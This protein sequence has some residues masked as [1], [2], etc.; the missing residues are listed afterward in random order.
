[1]LTNL[2]HKWSKRARGPLVKVHCAALPESLL[3]SELFGHEKGAFTG[4]DHRKPGKFELADGGTIFLDEIGEITLEVQV[5]L[6]RVL[7]EREVD[8]IGGIQPVPVD[9][10]VVA[11]TNRDIEEMVAEGTFR[12]DLYYRLQGMVVTVPPLR[13]RK[14]EI[15]GMLEVFRREA[16]AAGHTAAAG[17]STDAMDE[18]FRRDWPGNIRELRNAAFR[19]MVLAGDGQVERS[20]LLGILPRADVG[21]GSAPGG[22]RVHAVGTLGP[23]AVEPTVEI[24]RPA[25]AA[26]R[27]AAGQLPDLDGRLGRLYELILSRGSLSNQEYVAVAGVSPRTGLRDLNELLERGRI[28]RIGRRRGARY[29]ATARSDSVGG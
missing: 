24:S 1:V 7:Q 8:R 9:V 5:K 28:E 3:Q 22:A 29:R 21:L 6:L 2:L 17:F 18:L 12:E 13:E 16:V 11:A 25:A 4:A 26:G 19:A 27:P 23:G 10:R 15:P 14:S 20:H